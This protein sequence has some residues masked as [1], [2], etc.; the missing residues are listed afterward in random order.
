[1][2]TE[3]L[4]LLDFMKNP[5]LLALLFV[6]I[7]NVGGYITACFT[8]KKVLPYEWTQLGQTLTLYETFFIGLSQIPSM[9]IAW[10]AMIAVFVDIFRSFKEAIKLLQP[11]K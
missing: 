11:S 8:A 9:P 6:I 5:A 4:L 1:M 7:R 2:G 3:E 10:T